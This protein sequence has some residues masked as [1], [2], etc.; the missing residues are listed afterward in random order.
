MPKPMTVRGNYTG[1]GA[2]QN[3]SIGFTP[4][5]VTITNKTD[6]DAAWYWTAGH[7]DGTATLITDGSTLGSNGVTPYAGAEGSAAAGFTIG[8][9]LSE[10]AK[11]F[12]YVAERGEE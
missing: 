5:R 7:A 4:V 9:G 8:T 12:E 3:I 6:G 11:V 1:D 2:A 10:S